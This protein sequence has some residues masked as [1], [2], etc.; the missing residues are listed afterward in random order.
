MRFRRRKLLCLCFILP[1]FLPAFLGAAGHAAGL[2]DLAF[3]A[4]RLGFPEIGGI[5]ILQLPIGNLGGAEA[6]RFT[7]EVGRRASADDPWVWEEMALGPLPGG[8]SLPI[9]LSFPLTA[10]AGAS[11]VSVRLDSTRDLD[12]LDEM[13]NELL[14]STLAELLPP[15]VLD[16]LPAAVSGGVFTL[17]GRTCPAWEVEC[18]AADG[19]PLA[20]GRADEDGSFALRVAL[21]PGRNSFS[22]RA[23]AGGVMPGPALPA[24]P[25]IRDDEPPVLTIE[26]PAEDGFYRSVKPLCQA[27]DATA[28]II[29]LA[30]DG[31]AWRSGET[32][33]AVGRHVLRATARDAA[34]NL[35]STVRSFTIDREPPKIEISG[36]ENGQNL[37]AGAAKPRIAAK[38]E[39]LGWSAF[40]IDGYLW[41]D[42]L[43]VPA[44]GRHHLKAEAEDKAGN[45]TQ[46]DLFFNV[47]G[48]PIDPS[49]PSA[50]EIAARLPAGS[51]AL[52]VRSDR[53][54]PGPK[55]TAAVFLA[56][57][58]RRVRL[59]LIGSGPLWLAP[60]DFGVL[61]GQTVSGL[62]LTLTDLDG[63]GAT[64][65]VAQGPGA[66]CRR[67]LILRWQAGFWHTIMDLQAQE[68][69]VL[70]GPAG[71]GRPLV[72]AA[73]G[74]GLG[75]WR[76][77]ALPSGREPQFSP[78]EMPIPRENLRL[79]LLDSGYG[80]LRPLRPAAASFPSSA[81]DPVRGRVEIGG[82]TFALIAREGGYLPAVIRE[83]R[84]EPLAKEAYPGGFGP[85]W[86]QPDADG[87]FA[88]DFDGDGLL[89]PYFTLRQGREWR[90]LVVFDLGGTGFKQVF[91]GRVRLPAQGYGPGLRFL[92]RDGEA[93]ILLGQGPESAVYAWDRAT[94]TFSASGP[95]ID[96]QS[97]YRDLL[98]RDL[99][100][101]ADL[102]P[103]FW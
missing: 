100:L 88:Y 60:G 28:V 43:D 42:G 11:G 25:V 1:A 20:K 71:A 10:G 78:V 19:S 73:D 95:F 35:S 2:P 36:V 23:L 79:L 61:N 83:G 72:A 51:K 34:G 70:A 46:V 103:N 84:I 74:E 87:L 29:E 40:W 89:E 99:M 82:M 9:R 102:L 5:V 93:V 41:R 33:E 44:A 63:D 15:P 16:P 90:E 31:R 76:R 56:D 37:A 86:Q 75:A 7:V 77:T 47:Q 24:A 98:G 49:P 58:D 30:L 14:I 55:Q 68:V 32:I 59:A 96:G 62:D 67:L 101:S 50:A 64:E 39:A 91:R 53:L 85:S 27:T 54:S 13:N 81:P 38:D 69:L 12:E 48:K 65:I 66:A 6:G 18:F 97:T 21:A 8:A 92:A 22:L 4:P 45:R 94:G 17:R 80:F 3:G 52:I 57:R 26:E